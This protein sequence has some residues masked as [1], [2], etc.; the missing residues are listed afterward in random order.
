[1]NDPADFLPP[2]AEQINLINLTKL[3]IVCEVT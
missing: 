1:M 3:L 2:Q